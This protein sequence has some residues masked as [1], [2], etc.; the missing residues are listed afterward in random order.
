[1]DA[2]Y[3]AEGRLEYIEM[4]KKAY[5]SDTDWARYGETSL[6]ITDFDDIPF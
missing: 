5:P 3:V 2:A 1:M 6:K 4:Y